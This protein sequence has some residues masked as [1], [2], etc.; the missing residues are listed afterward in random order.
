MTR[1]GALKDRGW[2]THGHLA[3]GR[4]GKGVKFETKQK[5][6]SLPS[7]LYWEGVVI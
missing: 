1:Q 3:G 2:T 5:E 6:N 4:S 7:Q